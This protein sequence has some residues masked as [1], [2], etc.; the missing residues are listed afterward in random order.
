MARTAYHFQ[1]SG[2]AE[3]YNKKILAR[4][5]YYVANHQDNWDIFVQPLT[6]A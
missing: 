6:Y 4:L 3:K 1:K 2:L 5:R